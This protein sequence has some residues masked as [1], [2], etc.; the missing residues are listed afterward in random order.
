MFYTNMS[1]QIVPNETITKVMDLFQHVN[2]PTIWTSNLINGTL[3]KAKNTMDVFRIWALFNNSSL[4]DPDTVSSYYLRGICDLLESID[5]VPEKIEEQ[6]NKHGGAN[7]MTTSNH[8]IIS[9]RI[10][11]EIMKAL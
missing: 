1:E 5:G 10:A 6:K 3:K 11:D 2:L 4:S 7:R 8:A 9:T